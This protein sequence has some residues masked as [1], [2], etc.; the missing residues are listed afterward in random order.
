MGRPRKNPV[1]TKNTIPQND[2]C[3]STD[4]GT[5]DDYNTNDDFIAYIT[6]SAQRIVSDPHDNRLKSLKAVVNSKYDLQ[7]LRIM[8]GGRIFAN[9]TARM[10]LEPQDSSKQDKDIAKLMNIVTDDFRLITEAMANTIFTDTLKTNMSRKG[11]NV[12]TILYHHPELLNSS[13]KAIS[14][15]LTTAGHKGIITN[16]TDFT[17]ARTYIQLKNEEVILDKQIAKMIHDY[18]LWHNF[19]AGVRGCGPVMAA[20][21]LSRI[22]ISKSPTVLSLWKFCGLDVAPDGRGRGK[23]IE[24]LVDR[25]YLDKDGVEKTKKSITYDPWL[26]SKLMGVQAGLFMIQNPEYKRIYDDI[27]FRLESDVERASAMRIKMKNK[28]PVLKKDGSPEMVPE[29]PLARINAMSQRYMIKMYLMDM[30]IHWRAMS[31]FPLK[32]PYSME[33]LNLQAKFRTFVGPER[34]FVRIGYDERMD[35]DFIVNL[36]HVDPDTVI[37]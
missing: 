24:H 22:D 12:D 18:P 21:I 16:E 11:L 14:T 4:N 25:I 31:G 10:G 28:S 3:P 26:K 19:L 8:T 35:W 33:K 37:I 5:T 20:C 30:W 29:F 27:R 32:T 23:H 17:M 34:K 15:A 9:F 13:S 1:S 7:K 2:A 36:K 6:Q